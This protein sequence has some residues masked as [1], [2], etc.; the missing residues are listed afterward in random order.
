MEVS[1]PAVTL[2]VLTP[3]GDSIEVLRD[4]ARLWMT[5]LRDG[6]Q[7]SLIVSFAVRGNYGTLVAVDGGTAELGTL[8]I[9]ANFGEDGTFDI[10]IRQMQIAFGRGG[11]A[12]DHRYQ[13]TVE[14]DG[15]SDF[16]MIITTMERKGVFHDEICPGTELRGKI[17]GCKQVSLCLPFAIK[18]S[19]SAGHLRWVSLRSNMRPRVCPTPG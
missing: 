5:G 19:D 14:M 18:H 17:D 8:D 10:T 6:D 4:N 9:K 1:C 3:S 11:D 15:S 7:L 16:R 12:W 2:H 13:G